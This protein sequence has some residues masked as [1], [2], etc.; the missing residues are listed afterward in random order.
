MTPRQRVQEIIRGLQVDQP[1]LQQLEKL[2][3]EQFLLL[4]THDVDKL[5]RLNISLI[6]LMK[7]VEK[8]A[9]DR[10]EHLQALSLKPDE[11]GMAMLIERLPQPVQSKVAPLWQHLEL[12]L[13][14]CKKKNDRNG[15]LLAG[16]IETIRQLLGWQQDSYAG[17]TP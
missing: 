2:L 15:R 10:S 6:T 9:R 1:R 11:Q 7:E 8:E 13:L 14:S 12:L 16:Q 17:P 4:G 5:N 3:E